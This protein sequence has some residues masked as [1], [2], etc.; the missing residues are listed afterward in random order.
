MG[1]AVK[2]RAAGSDNLEA[3]AW[4]MLSPNLS[5][6]FGAEHRSLRMSWKSMTFPRRTVQVARV[7]VAVVRSALSEVRRLQGG[8]GV[9]F[10]ADRKRCS[11]TPN[12]PTLGPGG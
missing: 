3:A 10:D 11:P 2:K 4:R 8:I 5:H 9:E 7:V 1:V 12:P 6:I